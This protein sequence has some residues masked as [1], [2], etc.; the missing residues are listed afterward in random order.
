MRGM[1]YVKTTDNERTK[2]VADFVRRHLETTAPREGAYRYRWEHT[3]RVANYGRQIGLAEGANPE[4]AIVGCLLHDVG[5]FGTDVN[6]DHGR[7]SA[8][9]SRPVLREIGFSPEETEIVCHAVAVHVDGV[10]DFDHPETV[11]SKVVTDADNID[12]SGVLRIAQLCAPAIH[13][14]P[15]LLETVTKRLATL[16]EYRQRGDVLETKTGNM[17]FMRQ[18]DR[19]ISFFTDLLEEGEL[20]RLPSL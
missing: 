19:Q 14:Y 17:L 2:L 11:E 3:L 10:A 5:K 9:I 6:R 12:R 16:E 4:L 7:L 20:T 8:R 18:L 13:D 15:L 1:M